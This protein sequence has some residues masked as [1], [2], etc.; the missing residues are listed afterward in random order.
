MKYKPTVFRHEVNVGQQR[1]LR[2]VLRLCGG[3][4]CVV[5]LLYIPLGMLIEWTA[6]HVTPAQEK[7]LWQHMQVSAGVTPAGPEYRKMRKRLRRVFR[8]IPKDNLPSRYIYRVILDKNERTNAFAIPGGGVVVTTA[9]MSHVSDDRALT[10]VL[11]HELGH[12]HSR[13]HLIGLERIFVLTMMSTLLFGIDGIS[14]VL[15][16][17]TGLFNLAYSR[18][19]EFS[20]DIWGLRLLKATYGDYRGAK[21]FFRTMRPLYQSGRLNELFSTHPRPAQ[22]I[23]KMNQYIKEQRHLS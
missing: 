9:M 6:H 17:I 22:R 16:K 11:G 7:W 2:S 3:A 20:A 1:P 18:R 5:V 14:G 13:D 15:A 4:A 23:Y 21:I 19:Q 8:A 10:F 12:F